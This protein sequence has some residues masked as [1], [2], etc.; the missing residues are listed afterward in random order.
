MSEFPE[1]DRGKF[2]AIAEARRNINP[3]QAEFLNRLEDRLGKQGS[4]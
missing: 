3:Q 2:F 4:V 1:I